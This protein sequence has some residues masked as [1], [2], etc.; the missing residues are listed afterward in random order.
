MSQ[1]YISIIICCYNSEE[2]VIETLESIKKQTYNK[3]EKLQKAY[4]KLAKPKKT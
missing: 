1:I 4:E 3:Y 2:F